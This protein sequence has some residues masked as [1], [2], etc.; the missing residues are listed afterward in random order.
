MQHL[1]AVRADCHHLAFGDPAIWRDVAAFE[2][3]GGS[4]LGDPVQQE[5]VADVWPLD[6]HWRAGPGLQRI[7]QRSRTAGM[8]EMTMRQQDLV[9][10]RTGLVDGGQDAVHIPAR[11]D[12]GTNLARVIPQ[13][14]AVL[15]E[16]SHRDDR[17]AQATH[18]NIPSRSF[19]GNGLSGWY[20]HCTCGETSPG[21][22]AP[23]QGECSVATRP[24]TTPNAVSATS[25]SW[26]GPRTGSRYAWV[27]R[28]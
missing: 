3:E 26:P 18:C 9:D 13:D 8:V 27:T 12:D 20:C 2:A 17:A 19:P 5:L 24:A 28:R 21:K 25:G 11:I 4:L 10:L 7:A 14:G 6:R 1:E 22:Q 23:R 16:G 15:L